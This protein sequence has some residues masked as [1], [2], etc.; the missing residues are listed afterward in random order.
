MSRC[1]WSLLRLII[2]CVI[3]ADLVAT[4]R[5]AMARHRYHS[6]RHRRWPGNRARK[7]SRTENR[8]AL[9]SANCHRAA[10]NRRGTDHAVASIQVHA[11]DLRTLA[12]HV[13]APCSANRPVSGQS[14]YHAAETIMLQVLLWRVRLFEALLS[15]TQRLSLG[16]HVLL[17]L[18]P[19]G[20]LS[21]GLDR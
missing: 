3:V 9:R 13:F 11:W 19:R 6:L 20:A 5:R 4:F 16:R 12:L 7:L 8:A 18:Q 21:R 15:H 10:T 17:Q 2:C 1:V 14:A